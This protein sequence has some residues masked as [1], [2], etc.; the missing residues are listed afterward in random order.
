MR[1]AFFVN[2]SS[3]QS[4]TRLSMRVDV[5]NCQMVTI[6]VVA[7]MRTRMV[8]NRSN[9]VHYHL[10]WCKKL[11]LNVNGRENMVVFSEAAPFRCV[12][13]LVIQM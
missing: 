13:F 5:E 8:K 10:P 1:S 4:V 9:L 11:A 3:E 12:G 7:I 6:E 2:I